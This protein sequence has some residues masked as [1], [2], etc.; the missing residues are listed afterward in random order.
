MDHIYPYCRKRNITSIVLCSF[1]GERSQRAH[2]SRSCK[3]KV[4]KYYNNYQLTC[5]ITSPS[6]SQH[7]CAFHVLARI[8]LPCYAATKSLKSHRSTKDVIKQRGHIY[9]TC[10]YY[11]FLD[12]MNL[13]K[14]ANQ[15][16][17][18]YGR[19][20]KIKHALFNQIKLPWFQSKLP[21]CPSSIGRRILHLHI[22]FSNVLHFVFF[23]IL[24]CVSGHREVE[25]AHMGEKCSSAIRLKQS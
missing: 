6:K 21:P 4:W 12:V 10:S 7:F 3:Y 11:L 13:N 23:S 5:S 1:S 14:Q 25:L 20:V 19:E 15:P 9:A 2:K 24:V 16:L 22:L 17:T 8:Q 18:I